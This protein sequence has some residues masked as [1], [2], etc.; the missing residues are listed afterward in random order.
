MVS[1]QS[2]E[3]KPKQRALRMLITCFARKL[4]LR[5]TCFLF[6]NPT[7]SSVSPTSTKSSLLLS[8]FDSPKS[9]PDD[10]VSSRLVPIPFPSFS[11]SSNSSSSLNAN[12]PWA[13]LGLR[14]TLEFQ[15]RV[16]LRVWMNGTGLFCGV[17]VGLGLG[18]VRMKL[19]RCLVREIDR[20][21]EG[22]RQS[23]MVEVET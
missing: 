19:Q 17:Q 6:L 11:L 3:T 20:G 7:L 12:S 13:P 18:L 23:H 10:A 14:G 21:T 4:D 5:T 8:L 15:T 16:E 9:K 2:W 22:R 1:T